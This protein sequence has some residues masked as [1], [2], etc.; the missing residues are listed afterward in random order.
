MEIVQKIEDE[1]DEDD[2]DEEE[3]DKE[4]EIKKKE[5]EKKKKK[6]LCLA[7]P[8]PHRV[9]RVVGDPLKIRSRWEGA[10]EVSQL[11]EKE[12]GEEGD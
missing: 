1:E 10:G 7:T 8:W 9:V 2:D 5:K 12:G 3:E 11:L 4:E 6:F